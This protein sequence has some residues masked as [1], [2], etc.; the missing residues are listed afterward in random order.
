[1]AT[2]LFTA[3]SVDDIVEEEVEEREEI[4]EHEEE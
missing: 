1:M 3:I 4:E 2:I